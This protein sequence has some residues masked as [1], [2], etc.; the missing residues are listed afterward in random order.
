MT[1]ISKAR[2]ISLIT[3]SLASVLS[4]SSVGL[5]S[6]ATTNSASSATSTT[7]TQHLQTI[8]SKGDQEITRR[9]T[10]LSTLSSKINAA[11]KLTATDKTTLS[12]EVSSE[13]SELTSLK[14][15]L[16]S[17]TTVTGA[18]ADAKTI[19]NDYRVYALVLPKVNLVK[20]SDDIQTTDSRLTILAQK[21]Q[22]RITADQKAGKDVSAA[23]S[24][25]NDMTTKTTAAQSIASN[26]ESNVIILE[27]TDYNSNHSV[28]SG[29][30]AQLKTA[31]S[32]NLAAASDAKSI[33]AALKALE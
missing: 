28:L 12:N 7:S 2:N 19:I 23:Q 6:A 29:Y 4:I 11:T 16:D 9:L 17:E 30:N 21:L 24:E 14:T 26:I 13:I 8:I 1:I 10:S 22:T 15:K 31:H 3:F 32:D 33:V 20:F 27:P 18:T 5:A 25:L